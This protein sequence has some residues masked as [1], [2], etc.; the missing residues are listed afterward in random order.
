MGYLTPLSALY[1]TNLVILRTTEESG[2]RLQDLRAVGNSRR[3]HRDVLSVS[4]RRAPGS[5]DGMAFIA[6]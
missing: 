5:S 1:R 2:A 3:A 6:G 4:C